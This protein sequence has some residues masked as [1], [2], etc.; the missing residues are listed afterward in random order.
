MTTLG[1]VD[2]CSD[3]DPLFD[4][5]DDS[6]ISEHGDG[7]NQDDGH[8]SLSLNNAAG[9][10]SPGGETAPAFHCTL[11][12]PTGVSLKAVQ[13][14]ALMC[15]VENVGTIALPASLTKHAEQTSPSS[16]PPSV[17]GTLHVRN[18]ETSKFGPER[19]QNPT[20]TT[21]LRNTLN[22]PLALPI[23]VRR[24]SHQSALHSPEPQLA[25]PPAKR[26]RVEYRPPTPVDTSSYEGQVLA[27][28]MADPSLITSVRSYI[29]LLSDPVPAP[30]AVNTYSATSRK[31]RRVPAGAS[32]WDIPFPF[33]PGHAPEGYVENWYARRKGV[34]L[35]G[36]QENVKR[37]V[38]KTETARLTE[39]EMDALAG[40]GADAVDQVRLQRESNVG[41]RGLHK[42]L[43]RHA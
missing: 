40:W 8:G 10:K 31:A 19:C 2:S 17:S 39:I 12:L 20:V 13:Q 23:P 9:G 32:S 7:H 30:T 3:Y 43:T 18:Q 11:A 37:V 4:E 14:P 27:K 6:P 25:P 42:T 36:I 24:G 16:I 33:A 35:T 38:S 28:L 34:L 21:S 15:S 29:R 22:A 41:Y 26:L 1:D 5:S